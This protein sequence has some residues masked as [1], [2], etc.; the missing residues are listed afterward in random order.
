MQDR[1]LRPGDFVEVR[2]AAEILTTLDDRGE[3]D[4][5]PF[6]PEML[7]HCGRRFVVSSRTEKFCLYQVSRR[8]PDAVMLGDLRCD[9]SGHDGCQEECRFFWKESWLRRVGPGEPLPT[10]TDDGEARTALA[11]LV[12]GNTRHAPGDNGQSDA[13]YRCQYTDLGR[14][15]HGL[16]VWDPRAY[17]RELTSGNVPIGRFLRVI[18]RATI[19][20]T[21]HAL[22]LMSKLPL[23]PIGAAPVTDPPLGLQPGEWVQVKTKDEIAATLN[24]EGKNRG[25]WFDREMLPYCGKTYRV[26]MRVSR[27][28]DYQTGKM[29]HLKSDCL[30]LEGVVCSGDHSI[31][32]WFC[33]RQIFSYWRECWL[34]R[35]P[36][37][38][39]VAKR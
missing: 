8:I 25:L 35:V 6:M 10:L 28:I 16:A 38:P 30:K 13:R 23:P 4:A 39:E 19:E 18:F 27:L 1:A 24:A 21:F 9:G 11:S 32:R 17:L 29:I 36:E 14:A 31:G 34:R 2:N 5:L 33:A 15:S 22:G 26:R 7:P 3:L 12:A 37:S 20:E